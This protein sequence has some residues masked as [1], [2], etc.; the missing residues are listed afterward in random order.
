MGPALGRRVDAYGVRVRSG[1]AAGTGLGVRPSERVPK[2]MPSVT[3]NTTAWPKRTPELKKA[4][5]V[6]AARY[7]GLH[8]MIDLRVLVPDG[9]C[10]W[11]TYM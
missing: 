11:N 3:T 9:Y 1:G 10:G 4:K 5:G 6:S 7:S 8:F 2:K